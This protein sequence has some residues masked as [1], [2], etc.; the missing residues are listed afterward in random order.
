MRYIS[1]RGEAPALSFKEALLVGLADDDG[2][3][4]PETWPTFTPEEIRAFRGR[5]YT[6][7]AF[8]VIRAFV[9]G[10]RSTTRCSVA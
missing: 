6:E 9:G 10:E 4:V 5:P 2:L 7:V 8:R 3:Y 1:T